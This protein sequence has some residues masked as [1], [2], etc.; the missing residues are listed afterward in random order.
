[1]P[2]RPPLR[3]GG[4]LGGGGGE[5]LGPGDG[6]PR[7]RRGGGRRGGRRRGGRGAGGP[8]RADADRGG[9]GRG[10]LV[11]LADEQVRIPDL[12]RAVDQPDVE[13][14][15][16]DDQRRRTRGRRD[17]RRRGGQRGQGALLR[18]RGRDAVGGHRADRRPRA[19]RRI[20]LH[21]Q[22][23]LDHDRVAGLDRVGHQQRGGACRGHLEGHGEPGADGGEGRRHQVHGQVIR[24]RGVLAGR[25]A[26]VPHR[27][28]V[29]LRR[30][31]EPVGGEHAY[32]GGCQG[33]G[34]QG[35]A[36]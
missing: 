31:R 10:R 3:V 36:T 8:R 11:D 28:L 13:V 20:P 18:D 35:D 15:R 6:G 4:R 12:P 34:L 27:P 29:G 25:G 19:G 30:A 1:G 14:T 16:R 33:S 24:L 26:V 21:L 7:R 5:G 2:G 22:E 9:G 32:A 23:G 17:G